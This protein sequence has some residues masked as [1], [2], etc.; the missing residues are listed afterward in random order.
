MRRLESST[1]EKERESAIA[2]LIVRMPALFR[3]LPMLSGFSVQDADTLAEDRDL[4]PLD[5]DL[6]IADVSVHAWPGLQATPAV[7]EEIV[8]EILELLEEHPEVREL[9]R[10]Y[11]F[12]RAFH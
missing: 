3:R 7:C 2:A 6:C 8:S 11:T 10:G 4:V 9:L 5:A 12:A 1:H